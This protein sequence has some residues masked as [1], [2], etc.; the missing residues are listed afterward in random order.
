MRLQPLMPQCSIMSS[1]ISGSLLT[2]RLLLSFL[3]FFFFFLPTSMSMKNSLLPIQK[4]R[5]FVL[6]VSTP[7]GAGRFQKAYTVN[8]VFP[9][10]G[11]T[12]IIAHGLS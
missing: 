3:V 6:R 5:L 8:H 7:S 1:G 12:S 11:Y 4:M 10:G 2:S 9:T